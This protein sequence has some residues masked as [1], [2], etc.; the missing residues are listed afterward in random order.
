MHQILFLSDN[1]DSL[2]S[3]PIKILGAFYS[4]F[5]ALSV[6]S[7]RYVKSNYKMSKVLAKNVI[8]RSDLAHFIIEF[9]ISVTSN[10]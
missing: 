2:P 7:Y 3:V 8:F 4:T 1:K 10:R 5:I 6:T 9:D